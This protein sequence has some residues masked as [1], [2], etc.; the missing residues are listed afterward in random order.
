LITNKKKSNY[1][2]VW[3]GR[4]TGIFSSWEERS[5]QVSGYPNA[6]YKA[7]QDKSSAEKAF[8]SHY[9]ETKRN[10]VQG[11]DR[12]I[13]TPIDK[14][15]RGSYAVD[16][17]CSGNPGRLEFRCVQ[18]H[19]RT[20]KAHQVI[21]KEGPFANGTNNIGEFLAIVHAL[22]FFKKQGITR[23]IYSDSK[24]AIAWVKHKKCKT[25]LSKDERNANLFKL[26]EKAERWLRNN[27][28]PNPVLKW[29]TENWGEIPA[30]FGRK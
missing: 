8:R 19:P 14:P 4:K 7:F 12:S 29:K 11:L 9:K 23:P 22:I 18:I 28:Y 20:G 5:A 17:A 13:T 1:Y 6:K 24:N 26:I 3:K 2:V 21:F 30:D 16:A 25:Q 15:I 10:D 27:E